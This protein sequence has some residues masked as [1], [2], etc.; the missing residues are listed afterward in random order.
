MKNKSLFKA[1][2]ITACLSV[3]P[4]SFATIVDVETSQG[5]IQINLFDESTPDT[6]ANFLAYVEDDSYVDTVIHRKA[7]DFV[8]Q[9]GG[10]KFDGE[11]LKGIATKG[12]VK[13]EPVWSNVQGTIAMAKVAG[14]PD[15]A[16]SQWF[17][18]VEDNSANL[19][20]QNDG[21]TV[22]GQVVAGMDVVETINELQNC[23]D[24]PMVNYSTADCTA[25][26]TPGPENFVS[27]YSITIVDDATDTEDAVEKVPTT[28]TSTPTPTPTPDDSGSGGSLS[29][30]GL[31]LLALTRLFRLSK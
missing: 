15:S 22:F 1:V 2:G 28:N 7:K 31:G 14:N 10:F 30:I 26:L 27:I 17:F 12:T 18:N 13:N 5:T 23:G 3:I 19:D 16:T 4:T 9:G 6:V 24:T 21:F 29:F 11:G 8:V 20:F 25:N